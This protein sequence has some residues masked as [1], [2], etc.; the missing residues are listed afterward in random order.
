MTQNAAPDTQHDDCTLIAWG[1]LARLSHEERYVDFR[2]ALL[3]I[4]R[5]L[6]ESGQDNRIAKIETILM[7]LGK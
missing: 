3:E 7:G 5:V 1:G 4:D 6:S 2:V